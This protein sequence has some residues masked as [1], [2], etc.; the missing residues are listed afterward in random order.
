MHECHVVNVEC[1]LC[2]S[3]LL[4]CFFFLFII[5]LFIWYW[6]SMVRPTLLWFSLWNKIYEVRVL[7]FFIVSTRTYLSTVFACAIWIFKTPV[8]NLK[9]PSLS[10]FILIILNIFT[11]LIDMGSRNT[12]TLMVPRIYYFTSTVNAAIWV[13]HTLYTILWLSMLGEWVH[14]VIKNWIGV[15]C[16]MA[17]SII[18]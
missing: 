18:W 10:I 11:I 17:M 7:T 6:V 3:L 14:V 12:S 1:V 5:T 9:I 16:A 8:P 15:H 4:A 13:T 2:L